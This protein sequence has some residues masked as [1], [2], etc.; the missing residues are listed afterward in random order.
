MRSL[1]EQI[2]DAYDARS[3][4][5]CNKPGLCGHREGRV[6]A[7]YIEAREARRGGA[8][9]VQVMREKPKTFGGAA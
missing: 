8:N 4:W 6:E 3:C 9:P 5:L 1:A 7:A 2:L